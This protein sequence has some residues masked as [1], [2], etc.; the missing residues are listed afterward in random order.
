MEEDG[1][2]V[3][4]ASNGGADKA[5]AWWLNLRA[6]PEATVRI[7]G[8]SKAVRAVK[9]SDADKER[10]WPALNAMYPDYELYQRKTDRN[11]PVVFLEPIE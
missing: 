5:P 10:L 6:S 11:I 1:R 3:V 7:R 4:V 9:G 8:E 2:L